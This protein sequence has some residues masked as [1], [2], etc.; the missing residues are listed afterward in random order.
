MLRIQV[1]P[2]TNLA[3]SYISKGLLAI[4]GLN[5]LQL[6]LLDRDQLLEALLQALLQS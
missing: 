5:F 2:F 4:F 1:R 3:D 6:L